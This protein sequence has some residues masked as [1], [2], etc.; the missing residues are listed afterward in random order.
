MMKKL[1]PAPLCVS[2]RSFQVSAFLQVLAVSLSVGSFSPSLSSFS[3]SLG[4]FSLSVGSSLQATALLQVSAA[5][6][7]RVSALLSAAMFTCVEEET[8]Q[9]SA[10]PLQV[11]LGLSSSSPLGLSSSPLGQLLPSGSQLFP[12]GSQLF[13][14]GSQL[15]PSGSQLFPSRSALPL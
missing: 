15:F 3:P 7:L 8:L 12:S 4:S 13:P 14:S 5:P 1:G 2:A 9:V 10:A 11:P 6:P